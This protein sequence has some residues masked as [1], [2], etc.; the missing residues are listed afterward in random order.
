TSIYV[1]RPSTTRIYTLS[2]HD[3]LPIYG[4]L[5]LAVD[6]VVFGSDERASR[7]GV[8]VN[9]REAHPDLAEARIGE[10]AED[11]LGRPRK[12][13]GA[14]ELGGL[15]IDLRRLLAPDRI[16]HRTEIEV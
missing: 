4:F 13:R 3:A 14:A 2:L 1:S 9:A 16:A 15:R 11:L 10:V 8:E 6:A 12:S 7:A 5:I